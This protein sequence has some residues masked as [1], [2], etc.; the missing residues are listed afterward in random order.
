VELLLSEED[1]GAGEPQIAK[2]EGGMEDMIFDAGDSLALVEETL[3]SR[4][5]GDARV[6]IQVDDRDASRT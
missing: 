3:T 2:L 1:E 6:A 5:E 4:T